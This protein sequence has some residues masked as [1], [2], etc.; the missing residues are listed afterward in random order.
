[1]SP[2]FSSMWKNVNYNE[3]FIGKFSTGL[4]KK[5]WCKVDVEACLH[6]VGAAA[7]GRIIAPMYLSQILG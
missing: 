2:M 1:M 4:G 7:T 5:T 6:T 3:D